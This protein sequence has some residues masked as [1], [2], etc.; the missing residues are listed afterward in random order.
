[1]KKPVINRE[2]CIGCATCTGLCPEVFVIGPDGGS[3]VSEMDDYESYP[4]QYAVDS[5]PAQAI[6]W[7]E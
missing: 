4:V 1:M 6:T 3:Q 2:K 5:C 7:E